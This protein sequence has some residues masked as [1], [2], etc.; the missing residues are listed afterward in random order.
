MS[1]S[2][3]MISWFV[4]GKKVSQSLHLNILKDQLCIQSQH[5]SN[6]SPDEEEILI[7]FLSRARLF[8]ANLTC[9]FVFDNQKQKCSA[10][11]TKKICTQKKNL[12]L[13]T[14]S[15]NPIIFTIFLS[16]NAAVKKVTQLLPVYRQNAR[17]FLHQ[18]FRLLVLSVVVFFV[19]VFCIS[20]LS[21]TFF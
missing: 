13:R 10:S 20:F 7:L 8:F 4:E 9:N 18:T 14:H 5:S 3:L 17:V 11:K 2:C 12:C 1:R 16:F 21:S 15:N 6:E 19:C